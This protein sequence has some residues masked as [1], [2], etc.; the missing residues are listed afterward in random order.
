MKPSFSISAGGASFS[1]S[2]EGGRLIRNDV[3]ALGLR[4]RR[5]EIPVEAI[6]GYCIEPGRAPTALIPWDSNLV[7][8]WRQEGARRHERIPI[9]RRDPNVARLLE[10]L[11][12]LRPDASLLHLPPADALKK[13]SLRSERTI[14]WMLPVAILLLSGAGV[15]AVGRT[16]LHGS[17]SL[18]VADARHES[19]ETRDRRGLALAT[20]AR[21]K[22]ALPDF[23]EA[24]RLEPGNAD[25][26]FHCALALG[27]VDGPAEALGFLD[28][29]I[30]VRPDDA[31][32]HAFRATA[33]YGLGRRD[34][35]VAEVSRTLAMDPNERQALKLQ[36]ILKG[37]AR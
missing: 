19:A 5:I 9:L 24:A 31:K 14:L 15:F 33:L 32:M 28:R 34:E 29:A 1:V 25:Y 2:L 3:G 16:H 30:A 35:A 18:S 22:D 13:L 7:V 8:A 4:K 26:L 17:P 21:W 20:Q 6:E 10:D 37:Q 23:E 11:E 12:R 27:N 36:G